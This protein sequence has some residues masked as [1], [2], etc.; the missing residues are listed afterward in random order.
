ML[1]IDHR[2]LAEALLPAVLQAGRTILDHRRAGLE[3]QSKAD[4]SP[5]TV[6]DRE[7]EAVLLAALAQA[8]PG[9]PVIAEEA[10]SVGHCPTAHGAFFLVDPLDGTREFVTGSAEFTVNIGLVVDRAPRFGII[11]APALDSLYLTLGPQ[12]AVEAVVAPAFGGSGLADLTISE[13]RTREPDPRRLVAVASRSHRSS[14]LEG[15]L[16]RLPIGASRHIGSSLKFCLV[17]K[18]EADIYPRFGATSEW[19]TA[20]GH[21]IVA[22]AGGIVITLEGAPLEYGKAAA[23][24]VN[25]GFVVYG[26]SSLVRAV[27]P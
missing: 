27:H 12:R 5:V 14:Q 8:A 19:D 13:L 4:A 21:A 3:V 9:V 11:F 20:A 7:A 17:A 22:A 2:G 25:P 1:E 10:V 18:G 16:S 24:F 15:Y 6:A 23:G 26:R